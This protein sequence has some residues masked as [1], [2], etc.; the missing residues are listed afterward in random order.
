MVGYG[1]AGVRANLIVGD[2][3]QV[4]CDNWK[5]TVCFDFAGTVTSIKFHLYAVPTE[6]VV[7]PILQ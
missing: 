6:L 1:V 2:E 5:E 4:A 7:A 3:L